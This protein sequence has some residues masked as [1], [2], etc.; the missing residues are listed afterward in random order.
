MPMFAGSRMRDAASAAKSSIQ[1]L[2][3]AMDSREESERQLREYSSR[4]KSLEA[5][6]RDRSNI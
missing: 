1:S 2:L 4:W 5:E 3:D 6:Y